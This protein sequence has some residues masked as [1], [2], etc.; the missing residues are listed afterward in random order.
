MAIKNA[1]VAAIATAAAVAAAAATAAANQ[2]RRLP[3]AD[4]STSWDA[5]LADRLGHP[6]LPVRP[7]GRYAVD[8]GRPPIDEMASVSPL[9]SPPLQKKSR[10]NT[11]R[12]DAGSAFF[13][14]G[15]AGE[16]ASGGGGFGRG[17]APQWRGRVWPG[18]SAPVAGAGAAGV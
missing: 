15:G 16:R 3:P 18:T 17:R 2:P 11:E 13:G 6:A 7:V 14:G 1:A 8:G 10:T 12:G 9:P 4:P 5:A